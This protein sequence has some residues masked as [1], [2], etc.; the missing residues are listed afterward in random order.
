MAEDLHYVITRVTSE[1]GLRDWLL[2]GHDEY[3]SNLLDSTIVQPQAAVFSN[4]GDATVGAGVGRYP[5]LIDGTVQGVIATANTAPV[6]ADLIFD[7]NKNGTTLFT[8][9]ANRPTIASGSSQSSVAVPVITALSTG[10]YITVDIDQIG[11]GTAGADLVVAVFYT[12]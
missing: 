3:G 10:D 9:Q 1:T 2:A 8:T 12:K 6:G 7:V 4:P 11:S 5:I